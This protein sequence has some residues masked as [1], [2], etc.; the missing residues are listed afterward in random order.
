MLLIHADGGFQPEGFRFAPAGGVPPGAYYIK[1]SDFPG[2]GGPPEPR[3]YN[4]TITIDDTP[5][6]P[7]YWAKWETFPAHPN[8]GPFSLQTD[9][10]GRPALDI[11]ETWCW[12]DATGCDKV[13]GNL[14]SRSPWDHDLVT[15]LPTFTTM[16]NNAEAASNWA[17]QSAP[18]PPRFSPT[19][20]VRDYTYPWGDVW[21]QTDCASAGTVPGVSIDVSAAVTNLFV[22]HNRMHDWAYGLGFNEV[23]WNGQ[24]SQLRPD[25]GLAA[26]RPGDRECPGWS[27]DPDSRG[28]R[29]TQQRQHG[30]AGRR[31]VVDH[32]HVPLAA[33]GRSCPI[34]P[35]ADGDFDVLDHR[36][37]VRP[38]DREPHDR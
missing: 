1:V 16:G 30:D 10:W 21:N 13:V 32:E 9:P 14:L 6:P 38:H 7:A 17:H 37:R 31:P 23:N 20:P 27:R 33:V 24:K 3:T 5:A 35:C 4:G 2:G 22:A 36:P 25:R 11:R 15:D 34:P 8:P 29:R 28:L 12:R 26:G 19:S 18:V